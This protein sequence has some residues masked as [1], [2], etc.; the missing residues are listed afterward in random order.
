MWWRMNQQMSCGAFRIGEKKDGS[1]SAGPYGGSYLAIVLA[2]KQER[3]VTVAW[4]DRT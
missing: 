4:E 3:D 2:G 1:Y